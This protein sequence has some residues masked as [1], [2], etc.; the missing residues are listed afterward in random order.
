METKE[1]ITVVKEEEKQPVEKTTQTR[2]KSTSTKTK[3]TK[4]TSRSTS[5]KPKSTNTRAKSTKATQTPS[6]KEVAKQVAEEVIASIAAAEPNK[7]N[8]D[9]KVIVRNACPGQLIYIDNKSGMRY[10]WTEPGQTEEMTLG[11][12]KTARNTHLDFFVNHYWEIDDVEVLEY[13]GVKQYFDKALKL[14]DITALFSS[15]PETIISKLSALSIEEKNNIAIRV[16]E[17]IENGEI[18]SMR[19][20]RAFEKAL[21]RKLQLTE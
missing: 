13:L 1:T 16:Q 20:I 6:A 8:S 3:S 19:V 11:E 15:D 5:T 18:D 9:T 4:N 7:L 14:K 12:L 2:A 10:L 17:K 21:K